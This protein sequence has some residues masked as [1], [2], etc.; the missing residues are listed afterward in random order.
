MLSDCS[1]DQHLQIGDFVL[2][3]NSLGLVLGNLYPLLCQSL[4][5]FKSMRGVLT[6]ESMGSEVRSSDLEIGSS[7]SASTAGVEIDTVTSVPSFV[8]SS[9][10]PSVSATPQTFHALKEKCSLKV[11]TFN[12]SRICSNSLKKPRFVS[13]GRAKRPVPSLMV[14]FAF[15]RLHSYAASDFLSTHS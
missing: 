15:M 6:R 14:R 12:S 11:D 10:R 1:S 8:P 5:W 3:N 2:G 13:L 7:S 9:S 4:A